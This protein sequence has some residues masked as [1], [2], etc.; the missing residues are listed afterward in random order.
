MQVVDGAEQLARVQAKLA[1]VAS[2]LF[3]LAAAAARELDA[4]AQVG[5]HVQSLGDAGD[6]SEYWLKKAKGDED[7]DED[8]AEDVEEDDES[9]DV[10]EA[11][12]ED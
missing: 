9:E 6:E 1:A 8:E 7:D 12:D 11:E 2:T 10:D 4:N 5:A 3:P